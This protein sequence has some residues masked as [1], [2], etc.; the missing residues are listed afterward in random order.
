MPFD[1]YQPDVALVGALTRANEMYERE[2]AER[3]ALLQRMGYSKAET[4]MRLR[5]NV[6]W[7][8]ELHQKPPHLERVAAIVEEVYARRGVSGGGAPT[9]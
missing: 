7:D 1:W 8:F 6:L 4:T 9:L 3:A 5:T 2:L